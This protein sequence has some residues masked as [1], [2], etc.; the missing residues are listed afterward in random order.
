MRRDLFT[1]KNRRG[2]MGLNQRNIELIYPNNKRKHYQLADNKVKAKAILHNNYIACAETY[3]VI[4]RVSDIKNK[5]E[6]C[7]TYKSMAVK[8]ANGSGGGGILILKKDANSNWRN[9]GEPI[10]ETQIFQH[11]TS[12]V[13]GFYSMN[14]QDSCLIEEC[15]VPH[16]FFAEIYDEGVPDFRVITLKGQP[17]MA[18]LRMPTSKSNGK[19]NLHQNGVGIG[20]DIN[21]GVLTQTYDGRQYLDCHPDNPIPIKGKPIPYWEELIKLSI[22]TAKVFPLDYLGIDLV[23]DAKKGPQIM[24]VNVRPGLGIQLVNQMGLGDAIKLN[25]KNK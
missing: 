6:Q 21:K 23:I 5:W 3:A 7:K 19:A 18:M 13:S 22:D 16:P 17:I 14:S 11:I 1:I 24:E 2:V 20:V 9:G 25:Y 10:T 4:E 12:I 8:P 15:I